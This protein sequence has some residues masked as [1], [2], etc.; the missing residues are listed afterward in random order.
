MSKVLLMDDNSVIRNSVGK[1]LSRMGHEVQCASNGEEAIA[2]YKQ[3]QEHQHAFDVVIL[4]LA[5]HGGMGD[6]EALVQLRS[7]DMHVKAIVSSGY[8][9]DPVVLGYEKHGFHA[10]LAKSYGRQDLI[11]G[12]HKVLG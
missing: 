11:T 8:V 12:L 2:L 4:G 1:V 7:I 3:T 10:V 6:R 5:I 9:Y